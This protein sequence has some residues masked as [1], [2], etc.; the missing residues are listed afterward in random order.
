VTLLGGWGEFISQ[1]RMA[2]SI[3]KFG[4]RC[5]KLI[6]GGS[7]A[8]DQPTERFRKTLQGIRRFGA[9]CDVWRSSRGEAKRKRRQGGSGEFPRE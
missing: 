2:G 3:G 5:T 6:R 8:R 4:T 9:S 1:M 7:L